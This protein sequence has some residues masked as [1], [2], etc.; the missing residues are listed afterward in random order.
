MPSAHRHD[1]VRTGLPVT[2]DSTEQTPRRGWRVDRRGPPGGSVHTTETKS[3]RTA[4]CNESG[5]DE[6]GDGADSVPVGESDGRGLDTGATT[7]PFGPPHTVTVVICAYTERRWD[8]LVDAITSIRAQRR[9]PDQLVVVI[10]HNDELLLR[11]Q[12]AFQSDVKVVANAEVT[13]L[14][15]ARNTG[16]RLA[17]GDV[18]AFLDDDAEADPGWLEELLAH[19]LPDVVGA[20]GAALPVWPGSARPRWFPEEFDWVVGCSYR[21]LP[22]T[23]APQRNL[24]GAA[25]SFRRSAFDEVGE[26]DPDMGRLGTIPLGCEETEFSLRVRT[27]FTGAELVYVPRAKVHHHVGTER[28]KVRYF[29]RRCFAEGVS[30]AAVT[31]R[32][33]SEQALASERTYVRST[34]PRGVLSGLRAVLR[35]DLGGF[36]RSVMIV[37]GLLA[38]TAGYLS[39]RAWRSQRQAVDSTHEPTEKRRLF[40]NFAYLAS[41]QG[42]TA[43]I[44]LIYWSLA[45]H[46]FRTQDVGLAAAASST[47]FFLAAL[48][49]LGIAVLLLAEL[50]SIDEASRRVVVTTGIAVASLVVL[51]LSIGTMVLS[52]VLG[53]SLRIIADDPVTS[54]LFIIGGVATVA[55]I[56]FDNTAIGLNR[57][58]AQLTRGIIASVLKVA[59]LGILVFAGSRTTAGLMFSWAGGL[60]ISFLICL[61]MLRLARS[62]PGKGG[63]NQRLALIR[64]YGML[65]LNHHAL[66]LSINSA[67]FVV[68]AMA[69]LLILPQQV[70]YFITAD[71]VATAVLMIPYLLALSLFA[72]KSHDPHVLHDL[73]RRTLPLGLAACGALVLIVEV[74]AP[75]LLQI[76]RPCLCSE[77]KYTTS[78]SHTHWSFVCDQRSLCRDP[79]GAR[80]S[81]RGHS[82]HCSRNCRRSSRRRRRGRALGSD[83]TL[84]RVGDCRG[85]RGPCSFT[86]RDRGLPPGA[87]HGIPHTVMHLSARSRSADADLSHR[88]RGGSPPPATARHDDGPTRGGTRCGRIDRQARSGGGNDQPRQ[89]LLPTRP[90]QHPGGWPHR[91]V[92]FLLK[93]CANIVSEFK[94]FGKIGLD[95]V[96]RSP[97]GDAPQLGRS[98]VWPPRLSA[99]HRGSEAG[100][101]PAYRPA[102]RRLP[103]NS[104]ESMALRN[105]GS[106]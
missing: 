32:A 1:A 101:N 37:V 87:G 67:S 61:P 47:S 2:T 92:G 81:Q 36:A 83:R 38:T 57:G 54:A 24:I 86:R 33:G 26:F 89:R 78:T 7:I 39:P 14:S 70:A 63:L 10:D 79:Q 49:V 84:P 75:L 11:A 27:A 99:S 16:L 44:G 41:K 60:V 42:V 56:T 58:S 73:L 17:T 90:Q 95:G 3:W 96:V 94:S 106:A 98:D 20:G 40:A 12:S 55:T 85:V 68:P 4:D 45:T 48:G 64:R 102:H 5:R 69:A 8:S 71:L 82:G 50:K 46:L 9:R 74:A 100:Q 51:V 23:V 34:L 28:T 29:L 77:R 52:P 15:G 103:L 25:M 80:T 43:V 59:C 105:R 31:R 18:V 66:N 53:K 19:Y 35:G 22:D 88:G 91:S 65:S 76:L 30:K 62:H 104:G 21:G 13:G 72:A 97:T 6:M 93:N